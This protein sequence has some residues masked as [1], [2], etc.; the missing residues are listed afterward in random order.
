MKPIN[1][2]CAN[3][4]NCKSCD[5]G[6]TAQNAIKCNAYCPKE[7]YRMTDDEWTAKKAET[8]DIIAKNAKKWGFVR[9]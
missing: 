9:G 1:A 8:A 7:A 5:G 4:F 3:C 2:R 6:V